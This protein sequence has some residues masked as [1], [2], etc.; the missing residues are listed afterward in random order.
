M[1]MNR[2]KRVLSLALAIGMTLSLLIIPANAASFT[3]TTGHWAEKMIE[4]AVAQQG[5]HP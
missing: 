5:H 3:D 2:T 4:Q 1:R